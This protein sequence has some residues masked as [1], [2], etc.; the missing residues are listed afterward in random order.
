[1]AIASGDLD[2]TVRIKRINEL[3]V[4]ADSFNQMASQLKSSF[5][6]L[7]ATNQELD[8]ALLHK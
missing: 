4:L 8:T 2:Q 7:D 6:Q 1:M 5:T 3:S